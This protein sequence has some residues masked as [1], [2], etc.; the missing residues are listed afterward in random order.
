MAKEM[1][2]EVVKLVSRYSGL[3]EKNTIPL[4]RVG[5]PNG[6]NECKLI[7]ITLLPDVCRRMDYQDNLKVQ[8]LYE[9]EAWKL[10]RETLGQHTKLSPM[11]RDIATSVAANCAGLP[12]AIKTMSGSMRGIN[13]IWEWRNVLKKLEE[14]TIGQEDMPG[15]FYPED[16]QI[17]R[18]EIV[19]CLVAEGLI[20]ERKTREAKFD[21][22]HTMDMALKITREGHPR[23]MVKAGVGLMEIPAEQEWTEDLDKFSLMMNNINEI[24]CVH[25]QDSF[26]V[27]MHAL[28]FLDLSWNRDLEK[29]P[30]SILDLE[31]IS[32]LLIGQCEN[33]TYMP[34][35]GKLNALRALDLSWT[36][37]K[38]PLP[39]FCQSHIHRTPGEYLQCFEWRLNKYS[40]E[41]NDSTS[42]ALASENDESEHHYS[43]ASKFSYTKSVALGRCI[44][45]EEEKMPFCCFHTNFSSWRFTNAISSAA[46]A[47]V[48]FSRPCVVRPDVEICEVKS[49]DGIECIMSLYSSSSSIS[50]HNEETGETDDDQEELR[51]LEFGVIAPPLGTLFSSLKELSI[52]G[53]VTNSRT[54]SL[55]ACCSGTSKTWKLSVS[56]CD[57]MMEIISTIDDEGLGTSFFVNYNNC[58]HD[59]SITLPKLTR[60]PFSFL[61]NG[62]PSAPAAFTTYG[63][64]DWNHWSG[65][66]ECERMSYSSL[67]F[68]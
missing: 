57:Q 17:E 10:F 46:T 61:V 48:M 19:G 67:F 3:D 54:S 58:N 31:N 59:T 34:P 15:A 4:D 63:Y 35:L 13:D 44:I 12:L 33:L 2:R 45:G 22:G 43:K 55:L 56:G 60:L 38:V 25:L 30:N 39:M 65:T 37:I 52:R 1:F 9:K 11:V 28:Q 32:E 24:P 53:C 51:T 40:L 29:L 18:N 68:C 5:I 41:L 20:R 21:E 50:T 64:H 16:H 6:V 27:H 8:P 49:C 47:C 62:Q 42:V 66:T 23:F 26:F 7:L 14:L 36:H